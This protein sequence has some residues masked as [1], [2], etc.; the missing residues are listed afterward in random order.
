MEDWD[1][2]RFV[3]AVSRA[4][5]LSAAARSL[6][7][8]HSTVSRR[9]AGLEAKM[10]VRLFDR[11]PTG[12]V[13][14]DAGTEAVAAAEEIEGSSN[15]LARRITARDRQPGGTVTLTAPLMIV[16]GPFMQVLAAFRD[17]YPEIDIRVLATNDLLNLHRREA[18]IAI[19]ATD[20][21]EESLF[22]VRLTE[23][24]AAIYAAPAYLRRLLPG[25]ADSP[26]EWLG[27]PGNPA[28]PPEVLA[29]YPGARQ[30]IMVDDKLGTLAAAR[31]GLGA[32][33]L[34]CF[35][36]DLDPGLVRV[37]GFGLFRYPDKWILTHPDLRNVER[38]RLM[39]RFAAE[40]IRKR[41]GLFMGEGVAAL[42]VADA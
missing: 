39:I 18:D 12:H 25:G 6:G 2:L 13:P 32:C 37:P 27:V 42:S 15:A 19:R 33:R 9:I 3:L 11:L 10:G 36:G 26:L 7:V 23:Q 5:G 8:T 4:G 1:D 29:A 21:P 38:V 40:E 34:P 14:T 17:K 30:S 28:P 24:R 41:R 35:Q 20:T 22:G 16:M 31:V